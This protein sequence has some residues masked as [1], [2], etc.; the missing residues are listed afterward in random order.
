MYNEGI[1]Y[2][3]KFLPKKLMLYN[4]Q[5]VGL[6]FGKYGVSCKKCAQQ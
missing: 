6:P 1:K 3:G 5:N 2:F 4:F